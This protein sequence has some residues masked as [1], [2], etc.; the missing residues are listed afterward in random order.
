VQLHRNNRFYGFLLNVCELC[1]E[2]LL[3]DESTGSWRFM[4]FERDEHKMRLMF[5][6][7]IYNFYRLE[8]REFG[9]TS[10]QFHWATSAPPTGRVALLP[11]MNTDVSLTSRTRKIVIE[12]KFSKEALQV[13]YGKTSTRSEHLYQLYAYLRNLEPRGGLDTNCEG[14]LLYP[15]VADPVDFSFTTAGHRIRVYT[16][17]LRRD[18]EVI[19]DDLLSLLEWR[20]LRP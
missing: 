1:Y 7:F 15:S 10:E 4:D 14:L 5:Q 9:V 16:L 20:Q 17:N 2:S 19:R 6:N 11:M 18:W 13:Y 3:A 12:C 8:Q